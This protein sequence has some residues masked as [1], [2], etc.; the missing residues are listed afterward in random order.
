M[1]GHQLLLK[2]SSVKCKTNLC[3]Y[4]KVRRPNQITLQTDHKEVLKYRKESIRLA[5]G[6]NTR[7][8]WTDFTARTVKIWSEF[9]KLL[10]TGAAEY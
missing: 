2:I 5:E 1:R 9:Y 3:H 7:G 6:N 8:V 10:K 4:L